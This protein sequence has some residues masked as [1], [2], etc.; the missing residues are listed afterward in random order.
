MSDSS[1]CGTPAIRPARR[2]RP[3]AALASL[4]AVRSRVAIIALLL[5]LVVLGTAT[6]CSGSGDSA[7]TTST[8]TSSSGPTTTTATTIGGP[9]APVG[10]PQFRGVTTK[11]ASVGRTSSGFLVDAT[12]GAVGCVDQVTFTFDSGSAPGTEPPGY[13]VEYHDPAQDPFVDGNPPV[14]IDLPGNAFLL[15]T[16]KPALSIDPLVEGA[17]QTYTGNL[18]LAY[19]DHH[20]LQIVRKLPDGDN[21]VRWVIGLDGTR[22]FRVDRAEDPPRITVYIG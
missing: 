1:Y 5:L 3:A 7:T 20:Y 6:A 15:V 8:S 2:G 22:P 4:R 13:V 14:R 9:P 11:L 16:I 10:C 17:P 12:A 21:T 18:A 19:G